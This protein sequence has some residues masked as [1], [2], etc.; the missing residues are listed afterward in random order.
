MT[1]AA[2]DV[3]FKVPKDIRKSLKTLEM[4]YILKKW[5]KYKQHGIIGHFEGNDMEYLYRCHS[6][7]ASKVQMLIDSNLGVRAMIR[8]MVYL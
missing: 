1:C 7:C 5:K 4:L 6:M 2:P 3:S 8:T